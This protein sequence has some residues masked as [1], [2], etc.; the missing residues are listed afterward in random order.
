M[1]KKQMD[2]IFRQFEEEPEE[3]PLIIE[4]NDV[5]MCCGFPLLE[6]EHYMCC[7]E[8]GKIQ[9][10]FTSI[11][12]DIPFEPRILKQ[13]YKRGI[14]FKKILYNLQGREIFHMKHFHKIKNYLTENNITDYSTDSIKN[15][16]RDMDLSSYY[17]HI[18][19][20]RK[21]LGCEMIIMSDQLMEKLMNLF[22]QVEQQLPDK[23]FPNYHFILKQLL[24]YLGD[25]RFMHLLKTLKSEKKL[26][27]EF[28]NVVLN[29]L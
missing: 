5:D 11:K 19:L 25:Y 24:T 12:M 29:H 1:K 16:L 17:L 26:M 3:K 14:H 27:K 15:V 2:D 28:E 10:I 22:V 7:G 8:C 23:N 20:I 9:M 18:Q 6:D 4:D 21:H 13:K